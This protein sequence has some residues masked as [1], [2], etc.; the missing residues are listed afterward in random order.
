MNELSVNNNE[1]LRRSEKRSAFM[2]CHLIPM[3]NAALDSY[4]VDVCFDY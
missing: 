2:I 4:K 3:M 1:K